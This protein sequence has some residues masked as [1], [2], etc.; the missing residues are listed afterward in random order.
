MILC[1][2][3]ALFYPNIGVV[4]SY[5]GATCG[6]A[7]VYILPVIVYLAQMREKI[8]FTLRGQSDD[9]RGPT[10]LRKNDN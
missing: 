3:F 6:F 2:L 8:K 4:M 9:A 5:V 10:T 7:C 1:L